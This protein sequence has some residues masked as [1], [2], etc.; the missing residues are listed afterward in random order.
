[1]KAPSLRLLG[2]HRQPY[3]LHPKP[4]TTMPL[5]SGPSAMQCAYRCRPHV[6]LMTNPGPY[7]KPGLNS[8]LKIL[9]FQSETIR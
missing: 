4:D 5:R 3:I 6:V 2:S 8:N 7:S 1:M 9:I